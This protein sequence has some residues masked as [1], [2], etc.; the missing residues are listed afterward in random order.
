[1]GGRGGGEGGVGAVPV[2]TAVGKLE[3]EDAALVQV[4]LV[5][6]R[7]GVVEHLHV[8]ALHPHRQPLARRTVTQGEDLVNGTDV[9]ERD[10]LLLC[11]CGDGDDPYL[12]GEVV[13]LQL[14]A[15][16]QVPGAHCVIQA[17]GQIGRAHV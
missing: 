9:I 14:P 17:A 16:S 8:A 11:V 1:M 5:L 2:L 6:V 13:L 10:G 3:G 15:L 12:G 7:L 4:Q